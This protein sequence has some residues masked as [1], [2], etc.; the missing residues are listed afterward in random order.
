MS[1]HHPFRLVPS[2]E[3]IEPR[4]APSSGFLGNVHETMALFHQ[5]AQ[6]Q[7]AAVRESREVAREAQHEAIQIQTDKIREHANAALAAGIVSGAT[8][9]ASGV[10]TLKGAGGKGISGADHLAHKG[11]TSEKGLLGIVGQSL[12]GIGQLEQGTLLAIRDA[13]LQEQKELLAEEHERLA[14]RTELNEQEF[15]QQMME[16][17]HQVR[18]QLQQIANAQTESLR[19]IIRA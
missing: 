1:N 4:L 17:M 7:R 5:L 9:I 11:H 10:G 3:H 16:T 6:Q 8:S 2:V 18:E 13:G 15:I 19:A 14:H 12:A